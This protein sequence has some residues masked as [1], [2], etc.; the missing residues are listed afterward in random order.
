MWVRVR[1]YCGTVLFVEFFFILF[2]SFKFM[3]FFKV[4]PDA[5]LNASCCL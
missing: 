3:L 1:T 4:G 2:L 5:Y